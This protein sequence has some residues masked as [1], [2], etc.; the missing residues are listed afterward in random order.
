MLPRAS[1]FVLDFD[2]LG[3]YSMEDAEGGG[4]RGC[5]GG[6]SAIEGFVHHPTGIRDSNF[7]G[8]S[9]QTGKSTFQRKL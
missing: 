6:R 8:N 2:D 3:F 5:L 1:F 7:F 4:S 9:S